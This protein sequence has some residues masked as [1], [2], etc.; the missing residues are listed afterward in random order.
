MALDENIYQLRLQ[1]LKQIE[2]LGQP[3]YPTLFDFTGSVANR[4]LEYVPS[5]IEKGWPN[6]T[7]AAVATFLAIHVIARLRVRRF[8][9][10]GCDPLIKELQLE[11]AR[12]EASGF[13]AS[14]VPT[15]PRVV[16]L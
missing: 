4:W 2:A 8:L 15:A 7:V 10:S 9:K 6:W 14:K 3:A 1:K 13:D 16:H 5:W 11:A 12:Q